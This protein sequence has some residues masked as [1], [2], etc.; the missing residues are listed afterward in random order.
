MS[1][2]EEQPEIEDGGCAFPEPI[3]VKG[4]ILVKG[5]TA[6][7]DIGM[8]L[9][10]FIATQALSGI[11]SKAHAMDA[12]KEH[13]VREAYRYA[14]LMLVERATKPRGSGSRKKFDG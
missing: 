11:L 13:L 5:R 14:D 1:K 12:N 8:S 7:A 9:R 10:D 4:N 6:H 3:A 2:K